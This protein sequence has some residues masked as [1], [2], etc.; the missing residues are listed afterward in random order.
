MIKVISLN[1]WDGR[2][3]RDTLLDFFSKY[4]DVDVFCLQEM[5]SAPYEH[6]ENKPAGGVEIEH[7]NIMVNGVSDISSLLENHVA[8][9]RPHHLDNYGLM[10]LIKKDIKVVSEGDIFVH[11]K[12]GYIPTGDVGAHARNVQFITITTKS[13]DRSILNFHGL[14][15]GIGK[16]DSE[17]RLLQ[18]DNIIDFMKTLCD[19]YVICGDFNLLP[20]TQSI[21]KFEDFGLR[22]LIKE[23][24]ITS[25]RTSFYPKEERFA[26]Y[27]FVSDKISVH[28]FKVLPEEVSDH[29]ALYLEF[30]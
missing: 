14:W 12:R 29:S 19:P 28:T 23:N 4:S 25:T 5:W 6:L 11:E 22:N 24:G 13:G 30:E 10:T 15:N 3:G 9:F 1:T 27:A 21:R 16:N 17:D 7:S 20:T 18:S 26:D 2:A 8:Y